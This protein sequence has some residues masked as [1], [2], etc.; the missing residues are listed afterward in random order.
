MPDTGQPAQETTARE[1]A[2]DIIKIALQ[3]EDDA[4]AADMLDGQ[5]MARQAHKDPE[6]YLA[7][8]QA[9]FDARRF[10]PVV[11]VWRVFTECLQEHAHEF[12]QEPELYAPAVMSLQGFVLMFQSEP[13]AFTPFDL[14]SDKI[15]TA[16]DDFDE[17]TIGDRPAERFRNDRLLNGDR[18]LEFGD[19]LAAAKLYK[20][21]AVEDGKAEGWLRLLQLISEAD[22]G[23]GF[24]LSAAL[25]ACDK[26]VA[27]GLWYAR[28]YYLQRLS[29]A[30]SQEAATGVVSGERRAE[31]S[32]H[33]RA[34]LKELLDYAKP[35][36]PATGFS[37]YLSPVVRRDSVLGIF[38]QQTPDDVLARLSAASQANSI[39][40]A[41]GAFL[42]VV[43]FMRRCG[44]VSTED[45]ADLP[46]ALDLFDALLAEESAQVVETKLQSA[47]VVEGS[48]EA[49][50]ELFH[51]MAIQLNGQI[52]G[53]I[54]E[55]R[56]F[57]SESV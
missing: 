49:E 5:L 31:M 34:F 13:E 21:A 26:A 20:K 47:P 30:D 12:A 11:A 54:A 42:T 38:S 4:E 29:S 9:F 28:A 3:I 23:P 15:N 10:L 24:G 44:W 45:I 14:F 46:K 41:V 35:M 40:S 51:D 55:A 18:A 52:S 19:E 2:D 36:G 17:A 43:V 16:I 6:L 39:K 53:I 1:R 27:A 25:E 22:L 56:L 37:K 8:A 57:L 7:V 32:A 50:Q 48:F 33:T